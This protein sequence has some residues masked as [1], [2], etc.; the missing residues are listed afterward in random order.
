MIVAYSGV[1]KQAV[2][3]AVMSDL[4]N[5]GSMMQIAYINDNRYPDQLP[6]DIR[7]SPG[8]VLTLAT[9]GGNV[10][11]GL[12]TVQNGVLFYDTCRKLI[13]EGVGAKEDNHNYVS[14]CNVY[15]KGQ[16]HTDGWNGRNINTPLIV[17]SLQAYVS[18][19]S[20]GEKPLFTTKGGYFMDR[21]ATDFQAAGGSFPVTSFWDSWAAP[22]NGGVAK[23][24]LPAPS[25][26]TA[27]DTESYCINATYPKSPTVKF[28]IRQNSVP[29]EGACS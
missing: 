6:T 13:S 26:S 20:G 14:A 27:G 28:Y 1:Q 19:Y 21:L 7:T 18:S 11:S 23:P 25:G 2:K 10:Y 12:S 4:H 29:T 9:A 17:A 15:N 8:V 16:I 22:G 5:A 24:T 3:A